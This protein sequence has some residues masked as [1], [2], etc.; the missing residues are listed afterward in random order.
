M[1]SALLR[2]KRAG[3]LV[4]GK[5]QRLQGGQRD[6]SDSVPANWLEASAGR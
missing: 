1:E 6:K 4:V 3:Q 2:R 5:V